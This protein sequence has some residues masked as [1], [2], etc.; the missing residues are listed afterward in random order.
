M[1]ILRSFWKY[2]MIL[3]I[4]ILVGLLLQNTNTVFA[5]QPF[6]TSGIERASPS[7]W[8]EE[9]DI[10]LYEDKIVIYVDSPQW[11]KFTDTNSMDP[12]L[13]VYSNALQIKPKK[14]ELEVGDI[15]TY[16]VEGNDKHIIHRI[17]EIGDD[18]EWYAIVKGDNNK[19]PD[20][21]KV[22]FNQIEKVLIGI[23]Y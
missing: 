3:M 7:N 12:L 20:P 18:G 17:I 6:S 10:K 1:I 21:Y 13:D 9:K 14:E 8:V 2:S 5:E 4:G 16:S 15:I 22:R 19:N 11:S 23:I